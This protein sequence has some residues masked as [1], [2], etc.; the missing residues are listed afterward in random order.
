LDARVIKHS[1][2]TP[3]GILVE[4]FT[5]KIG[6]SGQMRSLTE[7]LVE[8]GVRDVTESF[9]SLAV[10]PEDVLEQ[11]V[12]FLAVNVVSAVIQDRANLLARASMLASVLPLR[13]A[14]G[15][16][17]MIEL[18]LELLEGKLDV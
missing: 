17:K 6:P 2:K 8:G 18:E 10:V 1:N 14:N 16:N 11:L 4:E 7:A 15:I 5:S 9:P 3:Y 12:S 13:E